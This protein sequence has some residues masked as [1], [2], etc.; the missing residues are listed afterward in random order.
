MAQINLDCPIDGV[1]VNENKVRL[2]AGFVLLTALLYL[3]T[4]WGLLL[5]LLITDFGLRVLKLP[6]FSPFG[7]VAEFVVRQLRLPFKSTD[8]APK[9]FAAGIGLVFSITMLVLYSLG[10]NTFV[11]TSTLIVFAILESFAGFCAG[12]YVYTFLKPFL[13]TD[14]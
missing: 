6:K 7:K 1:Q 13:P 8:Q 9:R 3:L 5:L 4:D 12:C 14:K 10:I 2:I 11:I